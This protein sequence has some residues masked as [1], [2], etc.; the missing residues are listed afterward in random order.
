MTTERADSVP[1]LT[2]P[3]PTADA[4]ALGDNVLYCNRHRTV[5]QKQQCP[6]RGWRPGHCCGGL[7]GPT[8]QRR[9]RS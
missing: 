8:P 2:S 6:G 9:R 1:D 3:V 7:K 4:Q 5:Q